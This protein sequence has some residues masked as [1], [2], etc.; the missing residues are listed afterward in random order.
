MVAALAVPG[1][2]AR[3]EMMK[4]SRAALLAA[5]L[6]TVASPGRGQSFIYVEAGLAGCPA[7]PVATSAA[8][9]EVLRGTAQSGLI[10]VSCGFKHGSYTVSLNA[11]DPDAR[12]SPKTFIVNFGRVMGS[13]SFTVTFAN[14]GVHTVSATI[15]SN[16][17]SPAVEGRFV[18]SAS[19]FKV[20][21][22]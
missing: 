18:S 22:D 15:T 8:P 16:M 19:T 11:S 17:G 4:V 7:A 3:G 20:V 10:Q 5:A 13:G 6:T 9:K 12:I 14:A 21:A 2:T 1:L